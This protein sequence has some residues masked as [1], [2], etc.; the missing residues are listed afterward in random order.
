MSVAEMKLAA[1][2]HLI[3]L[4]DEKAIKEVLAHL[5]SLAKQESINRV[6]AIGSVFNEAVAQYGNTLKKL[7]E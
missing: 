7:A 2:N 1:M 3:H 5:E 4:E 6:D